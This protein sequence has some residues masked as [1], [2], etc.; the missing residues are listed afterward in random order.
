[1]LLSADGWWVSGWEKTGYIELEN[2]WK[3]ERVAV[4]SQALHPGSPF[5]PFG[6]WLLVW[7][8]VFAFGRFCWFPLWKT[9]SG[10][11]RWQQKIV[12]SLLHDAHIPP[13]RSCGPKVG[14]HKASSFVFNLMRPPAPKKPKVSCF[15]FERANVENANAPELLKVVLRQTFF[16]VQAI[17]ASYVFSPFK[18]KIYHWLVLVGISII[19]AN[20]GHVL[21]AMEDES[22]EVS[23]PIRKGL[24][25]VSHVIFLAV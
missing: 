21:G 10:L 23:S 9:D 14:R 5:G 12:F 15:A 16:E 1:M 6:C 18:G 7:L 17:T 13:S 2:I 11:W 3:N 20:E 22:L 25:E 19:T 4:F 8:G 24:C